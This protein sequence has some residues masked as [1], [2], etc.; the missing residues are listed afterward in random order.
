MK[1]AQ[2]SNKAA[3]LYVRLGGLPSPD[4]RLVRG[5]MAEIDRL[6]EWI[7][8]EGMQ[9]DTCT[10]DVLGEICDGC[11]CKRKSVAE[12]SSV[13]TGSSPGRRPAA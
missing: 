4:A 9:T 12:D 1:H 10:Y 3:A 8:A 13:A 7:T 5:L 6:R 2:L 11:R